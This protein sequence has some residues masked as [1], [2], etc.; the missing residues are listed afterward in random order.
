MYR[1]SRATEELEP[2]CSMNNILYLTFNEIDFYV[3]FKKKKKITKN[4]Q[5]K[6][7]VIQSRIIAKINNKQ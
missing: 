2:S 1:K 6:N 4:N 3:A 7:I 5:F